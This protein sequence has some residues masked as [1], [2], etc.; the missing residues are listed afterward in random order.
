MDTNTVI[1]GD[2]IEVLGRLP[3]GSADLVFA[4]PPF[5]IGYQYDV[6][7]DRRAKED[8]LAWSEQW[9]ACRRRAC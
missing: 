3:A 8:Y 9:L 5:N 2:C 6:Y 1:T 7:D 4:D